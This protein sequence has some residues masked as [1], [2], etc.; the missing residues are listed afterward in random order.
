MPDFSLPG[1]INL[2]AQ[3][4]LR[5]C[6]G[7]VKRLHGCPSEWD[8]HLS[9]LF[10][11]EGKRDTMNIIEQKVKW[12]LV[13]ALLLVIVVWATCMHCAGKEKERDETQLPPVGMM[14][15]P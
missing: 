7:W 9:F 2:S 8:E 4:A 14:K 11:W 12:G 15:N 5:V 3:V 10:C 1:K 13:A 6:T